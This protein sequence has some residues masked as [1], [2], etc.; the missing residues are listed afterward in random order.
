[1]IKKNQQLRSSQAKPS[2]KSRKS[3]TSVRANT[4]PIIGEVGLNTQDCYLPLR[5]IALPSMT[6]KSSTQ[7]PASRTKPTRYASCSSCSNS[8]SNTAVTSTTAT[9]RTGQL[10]RHSLLESILNVMIGYTIA[11]LT[12][13]LVFPLFGIQIPISSQLS[14]GGIFTAVSIIRSYYVRRF[15][16][17]L[18]LKEVL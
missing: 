14:I 3:S 17:Y 1:M 6:V 16:N 13:I 7:R 15:F 9:K 8:S 4:V 11:I 12:Q 5:D 10:K 18:H 2:S